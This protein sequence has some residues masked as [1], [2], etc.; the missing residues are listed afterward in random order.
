[1]YSKK[2][3]LKLRKG[4]KKKRKISII[5]YQL[6]IFNQNSITNE[7]KSEHHTT[8]AQKKKK[9]TH[10]NVTTYLF[11]KIPINIVSA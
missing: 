9:I 4:E 5:S 1:M 11:I 7:Y 3:T 2:E 8:Y 10:D 6:C